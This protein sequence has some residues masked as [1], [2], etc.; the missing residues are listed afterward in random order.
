MRYSHPRAAGENRRC[1]E[2]RFIELADDATAATKD[3]PEI[4]LVAMTL[5]G[6]R[7]IRMFCELC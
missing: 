4:E 3:L 7:S 1:G 5:G 6:L 2:G